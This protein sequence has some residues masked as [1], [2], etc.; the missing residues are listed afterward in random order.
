MKTLGL[1]AGAG[2]AL[3][4]C[5]KPS[6]PATEVP[7]AAS[8]SE[9]CLHAEGCCGG[10]VPG[11]ASCGEDRAAAADPV[12]PATHPGTE[13]EWSRTWTIAPGDMAEVNLELDA[14]DT[15]TA[16]F[17]TDG[18]P[19][20]WNVHSHEGS[21]A[22]IHSEGEDASG[23]LHHGVAKRGMYSFLWRNEGRAPV[24]LTVELV[25]GAGKV[26]STHPAE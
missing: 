12:D 7:A 9:S 24:R 22:I 13:T 10:H 1:L 6:S 3:V 11:D 19:L 16:R 15:M 26:H 25:S 18:D 14:G 8:G 17:S 5:A 23:E 21:H 4:A 2:V 20:K